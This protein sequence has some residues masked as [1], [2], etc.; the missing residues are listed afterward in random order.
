MDKRTAPITQTIPPPPAGG[1]R[2]VIPDIHGCAYTLEALLDQV[3]LT[4][5]DQ[6]FLLGDYINKGPNSR[7]VIDAILR[8]RDQDFSLF[9]LRGNHE[10]MLLDLHEQSR[11]GKVRLNIPRLHRYHGLVNR[12]MR[13]LP[14]YI[15]FF[16]TLPYYFDLGDFILVH[17]GFDFSKPKPFQNT[18]AMLW[19]SYFDLSEAPELNRRIIH[20]HNPNYLP[21]IQDAIARNSDIIPLDNGCVYRNKRYMGNLLCLNLDDM[22]LY[23]QRNTE[24]RGKKRNRAAR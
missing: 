19:T 11:Y 1:R 3:G 12:N 5:S 2:L 24:P 14:H 23:L 22:T 13:I 17:A 21:F 9:A 18:S 6:L 10:Q 15:D 8:L 7:G 20:G 16:E 4:Y